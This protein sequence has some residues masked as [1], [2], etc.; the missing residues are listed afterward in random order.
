MKLASALDDLMHKVTWEEAMFEFISLQQSRHHL[1][2]RAGQAEKAAA[3]LQAILEPRSPR[4]SDLSHKMA[5]IPLARF[6]IPAPY[7]SILAPGPGMTLPI[8][9][10]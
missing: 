1:F 4:L 6:W 5:G 7:R 9:A 8:L 10:P 2:D 3:I